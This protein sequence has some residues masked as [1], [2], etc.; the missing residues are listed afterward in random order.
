MEFGWETK[1]ACK[2]TR[3]RK[4]GEI[5]C[6]ERIKLQNVEDKKT[7][8][9]PFSSVSIILHHDRP[10]LTKY[11]K[12]GSMAPIF[13]FHQSLKLPG[14]VRDWSSVRILT[15]QTSGVAHKGVLRNLEEQF[16]VPKTHDMS[17][18]GPKKNTL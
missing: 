1:L 3:P 18:H 11:D 7:T 17:S 6:V 4:K 2:D 9:I 16:G 13:D 8:K 14:N 12:L 10:L 15:T 5:R